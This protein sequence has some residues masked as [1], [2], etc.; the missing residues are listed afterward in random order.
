MIAALKAAG[1]E[2]K[3]SEF[4]GVGHLS[5]DQAYATEGLFDWMLKQESK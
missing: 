3:Y 1:G 4:P 2:P 5:W